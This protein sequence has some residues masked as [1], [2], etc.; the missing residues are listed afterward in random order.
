[1]SFWG[2]EIET[3]SQNNITVPFISIHSLSPLRDEEKN[4]ISLL[5]Y[6]K[7][8]NIFCIIDSLQFHHMYEKLSSLNTSSFDI[9]KSDVFSKQ[10]DLN[11]STPQVAELEELKELLSNRNT[12]IEIY[13]RHSDMM[14][15]FL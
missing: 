6:I 12:Q 14:E 11:I 8:Q 10:H 4:T 15:R 9:L 5:E 7:N 1:M 13:S 2:N 3:L